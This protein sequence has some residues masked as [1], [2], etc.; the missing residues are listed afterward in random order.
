S[1]IAVNIPAGIRDGEVIRMTGRGEAV[2]NGTPG[3]L[4]VKIHVKPDTYITRE[5]ND[6]LRT[7]P[8]KLT[9][10]LLG[11]TYSVDTLDGAVTI[12]VPAGVRHGE[13][14][15][16]KERGVPAGGRKRGD[17][18][19]RVSIEMPTRLSRK[20]KQLIEDLREEG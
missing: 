19:V 8:V 10:A 18:L 2:P 1:E 6:L 17:F 4:Y 13:R 7:L 12:K 5:G 14:L 11:G 20:A 15:R 16:I 9:D 3:D